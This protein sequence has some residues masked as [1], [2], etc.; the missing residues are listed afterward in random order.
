MAKKINIE[1]EINASG[2]GCKNKF[3]KQV[4]SKET[5][6][7]SEVFSGRNFKLE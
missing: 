6:E 1:L 4:S 2:F 7:L 3:G 5:Q